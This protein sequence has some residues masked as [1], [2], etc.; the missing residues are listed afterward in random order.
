MVQP[1]GV[2]VGRLE[3]DSRLIFLLGFHHYDLMTTETYQPCCQ[4]LHAFI[5]SCAYPRNLSRVLYA[6]YS[7]V[8]YSEPWI[9][10]LLSSLLC[11]IQSIHRVF[12]VFCTQFLY[13]LLSPIIQLAN[14]VKFKNN[15]FPAN[16]I[17]YHRYITNHY[18]LNFHLN[19]IFSKP[20]NRP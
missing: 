19:T 2:H 4:V 11:C 9:K 13:H 10:S 3:F 17:N 7:R 1:A 16:K 18:H 5:Q 6:Q 15:K 14:N 20:K 12:Q 8:F